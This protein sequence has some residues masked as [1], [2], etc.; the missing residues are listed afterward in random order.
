MPSHFKEENT[1][2]LTS[3]KQQ[4]TYPGNHLVFKT[5]TPKM[6]LLSAPYCTSY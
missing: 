4:I 6:C 1:V 2:F 3:E 5:E